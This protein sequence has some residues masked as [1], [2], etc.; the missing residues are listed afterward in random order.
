MGNETDLSESAFRALARR[1]FLGRSSIGLGTVALTSLLADRLTAD[2]AATVPATK[3]PI[4]PHFP[5]RASRVIWLTQ[6]GAPSQLELFD[7]KPGLQNRFDQDLPDSIRQGQ[8]LTGMTS[9][10]KRFPIA[11]SY[12]RFSPQGASGLWMSELLPHTS[13]FADE[14]CIIRSMH[15]EAINHD[16]AMTLLQTGHQTAGRPA[17]GAWVSYGLGSVNDELPTFVAMISRPSGPTNAQPLHERMWGSGFLPTRYQGVRFSS[18]KDPVLFLSNPSGINGSRRRAML[19]DLSALN[20]LKYDDYRDPETLA[21][22]DQYEMAFRMQA[23]V[24]ELADLSGEPKSV[25][26]AYGPES[27]KPG[28]F[29]ANCILARRLAERGVRFIQLYHRG[30]D[31]HNNLPS[32]IKSQCYD[33]DQPTG[34]L[35]NELK[36]RGLLE[37]TLVVWGG[38]FGRSVYSQGT[39]THDNYGRDHH[40]RCFSLWMAGAGIRGGQFIGET[41]DFSYNIVRDPVHI[42]DLNATAM[43]LL[44]LDH[45]R[46]TYRF[47]GRD[48]RLTDVHGNIIPGLT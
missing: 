35:L 5:P 20:L 45:T 17:F 40:P 37:D 6:A 2:V 22:I 44:G 3:T 18:G 25:F 26:E 23:S 19:D 41:D 15:T 31:Q 30:W 10:Q 7:Y 27:T 16:P 9:G 14:L 28:T 38:E 39:L 21:R 4:G 33:T 29:A 43:H 48:Y 1:Q 36:Q 12:Y 24:P 8:R 47:Q 32:G 13:K 11:P 42:H 46:L 34:A